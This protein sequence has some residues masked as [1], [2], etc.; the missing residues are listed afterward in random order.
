MK[1]T[2]HRALSGDERRGVRA[3][4]GTGHPLL[5]RTESASDLPGEEQCHARGRRE[6][7]RHQSGFGIAGT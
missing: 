5:Q 1:V 3:M 4:Q 6:T 2:D 7:S